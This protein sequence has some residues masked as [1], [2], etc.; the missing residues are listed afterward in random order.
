M[1]SPA[2][3]SF[4]HYGA[5]IHSDDPLS[6]EKKLPDG[7]IWKNVTTEA[8]S[9][10]A[11]TLADFRGN[12]L[13][14]FLD[15]NLRRFNAEVPMIALWDDHDVLDNWYREKRLDDDPRYREKDG[16]GLARRGEG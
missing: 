7:R 9:R 1:R 15:A 12:H 2:P 8:K 16:R 5:T 13:Y 6:S 14:N 11:Q 3:A 10:V 4:V